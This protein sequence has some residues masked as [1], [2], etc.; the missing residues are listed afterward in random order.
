MLWEYEASEK[1]WAGMV[2][3]IYR[4]VELQMGLYGRLWVNFSRNLAREA[5]TLRRV[6]LPYTLIVGT[7]LAALTVGVL[8]IGQES[9]A[10]LITVLGVPGLIRLAVDM[11]GIIRQPQ[12]EWIVKFFA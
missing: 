12:S 9:L 5:V 3:R 11:V 10:L 2:Q 6:L 7:V 1:L 4:E 8:A